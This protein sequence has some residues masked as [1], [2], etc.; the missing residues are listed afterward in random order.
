MVERKPLAVIGNRVYYVLEDRPHWSD[1]LKELEEHPSQA[2]KA[3]RPVFL[4]KKQHEEKM[5]KWA[6]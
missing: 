4:S 5:R 1:V 6:K 2:S 3:D